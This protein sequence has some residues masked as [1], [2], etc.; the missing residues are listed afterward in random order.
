MRRIKVLSLIRLMFIGEYTHNIDNKKRLAVPSKFRKELGER[1]ILTK[2][3]DN[4]LFIYPEQEWKNLAQKLAQL[5]VGQANARNFMRLILSGAVE[6]AFDN[7]GRILV[8]DY[9]KNYAGLKKKIVIAGV[10]NRLE[11]WDQETWESSRKEIEKNNEAIA[12]K[13]GELGLI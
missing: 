1:A 8:P 5:S 10:L 2:G 9:L 7:L 12:E 11:V 13:L 4:C 6:V 3:L